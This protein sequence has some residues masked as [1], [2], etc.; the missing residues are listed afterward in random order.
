MNLDVQSNLSRPVRKRACGAH[1][2][3]GVPSALRKPTNPTG[4]KGKTHAS[5]SACHRQGVGNL[6]HEKGV[7][8]PAPA[9]VPGPVTPAPAQLVR[10]RTDA[11]RSEQIR[12]Y[13]G[14]QNH[15]AEHPGHEPGVQRPGA[16]ERLD[17][18]GRLNLH[19]VSFSDQT[20]ML[21]DAA[22]ESDAAVRAQD[23]SLY[24]DRLDP[25]RVTHVEKL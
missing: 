2:L 22:G 1:F 9:G 20:M 25:R 21:M 16:H 4:K 8:D 23:W 5:Q 14:G 13:L 11:G 3:Q 17:P 10:L 12:R 6:R 15:R 19:R 18:Q 7:Q 24:W